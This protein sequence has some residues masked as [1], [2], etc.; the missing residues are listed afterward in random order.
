[1]KKFI[2]DSMELMVIPAICEFIKIPNQS[3]NYDPDWKS[4]KLQ[5]QACDFAMKYAQNLNVKGLKMQLVHE[6]EE[7]TPFIF[8][9]I[10]AFDGVNSIEDPPTSKTVVLYGH[11]DKQPPLTD[12]WSEGLYPY[13]PVRKGNKLYGRGGADDGYAFFACTTVIKAL[14]VSGKP[15]P[16]FVLMFETDE[17]SSSKDMVYY[18]G[19]FKDQIGDPEVIFCFDSGTTDY[20]HLTLTT[21]LRGCLA[22]KMRVSVLKNGVHS[23]DGGGVIPS[24]FRIMRKILNEFEDPDT[25]ELIPELYV[26]IPPEKYSQASSLL[27]K[28]GGDIDYK[29]PFE[30]GVQKMGKTPLENY[31]NR[32]WKPQLAITGMSGLPSTAKAGNVLLP[33]TEALISMRLPPTLDAEKAAED[34]SNFLDSLE[35]LNHATFKYEF[36]VKSSGYVVPDYSNKLL[37]TLR[38]AGAQAFLKPLLLSGDGISIPFMKMINEVYPS[39][40]IVMAGVLGPESNAH[41]P[42]EML[43]V[44]YLEKLMVSMGLIFAD[45]SSTNQ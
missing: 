9:E 36:L 41:C 44:D 18:M 29:F 19:K 35:I 40:P 22:L 42:N 14:Q 4:A 45:L 37:E 27:K 17:E 20:D 39:V 8:V 21:S 33:Y 38:T 6:N 3:R 7:R 5:L 10:P 43:R 25:G 2:H 31:I 24:S 30:E 32:V 12:Q 11:L 26:D 16:R 23:G 15:H 1:M 28:M 34:V 13:I